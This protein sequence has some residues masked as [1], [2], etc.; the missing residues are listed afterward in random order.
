MENWA[1]EEFFFKLYL[2]SNWKI[3]PWSNVFLRLQLVFNWKLGP[4]SR[5]FFKAVFSI[6][7]AILHNL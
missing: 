7:K 4:R 1:E 6:I 3:G 2:V 5:R